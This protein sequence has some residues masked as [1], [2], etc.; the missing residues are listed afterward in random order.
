MCIRDSVIGVPHK[1]FGET[2]VAV[3][4]AESNTL[5][6]TE[7]Q[8]AVEETLAR[9]KH[10]KKLIVVDELPRNTMGKVQK[11]LLRDKYNLLFI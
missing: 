8:N 1:D 4:V 6:L 5:D 7:V 2:V 11:N 3:L 9:Y 10:P